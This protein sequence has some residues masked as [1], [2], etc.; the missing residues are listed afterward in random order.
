LVSGVVGAG[1]GY[2]EGDTAKGVSIYAT[3]RILVEGGYFLGKGI[4][5]IAV[6]EAKF[7]LRPLLL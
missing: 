6:N 1:I 7:G 2:L 5:S 4:T 3:V